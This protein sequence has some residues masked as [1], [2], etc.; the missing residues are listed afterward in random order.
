MNVRRGSVSLKSLV[1]MSMHAW[2]HVL[3]NHHPALHEERLCGRND[4]SRTKHGTTPASTSAHHKGNQH[5][6][7]AKHKKSNA[8]GIPTHQDTRQTQPHDRPYEPCV[9]C[10]YRYSDLLCHF[11]I[12]AA[13]EGRDPPFSKSALEAAAKRI[14]V[15]VRQYATIESSVRKHFLALYFSRHPEREYAGDILAATR[16]G[17]ALVQLT[18]IGIEVEA[19][20]S[21]MV[22]VGASCLWRVQVVEGSGSMRWSLAESEEAAPAA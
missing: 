9:M 6:N 2:L 1:Q 11:Q 18:D 17:G 10:A 5:P 19:Q 16:S 4:N 8:K 13:L 22:K 3:Y 14:D 15:K 12:K 20:V 7:Q 21:G